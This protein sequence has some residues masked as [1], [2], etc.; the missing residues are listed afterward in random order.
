MDEWVDGFRAMPF[1]FFFFNS[2]VHKDD[3]WLT[4]VQDTKLIHDSMVILLSACMIA[5]HVRG[6]AFDFTV[7]FFFCCECPSKSSKSKAAYVSVQV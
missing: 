3:P 6:N 7:N 1:H 2:K 4:N 5:A